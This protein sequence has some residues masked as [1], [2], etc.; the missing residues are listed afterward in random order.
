V[1]AKVSQQIHSTG[2]DDMKTR[3]IFPTIVLSLLL[4]ACVAPLPA[5]R[6][7]LPGSEKAQLPLQLPTAPVR[8]SEPTVDRYTTMK[9]LYEAGYQPPNALLD[10]KTDRYTA[11]KQLYEA[12]YQPLNALLNDNR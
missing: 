4:A 1:S 8:Q 5:P 11:M 10:G 6:V 3:L 2:D 12:G 7:Q 9:Q